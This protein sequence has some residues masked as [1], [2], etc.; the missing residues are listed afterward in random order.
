MPTIS[1]ETLKP[2]CMRLCV[3]PPMHLQWGRSWDRVDAM[4]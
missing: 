2:V 1:N 4:L 3:G